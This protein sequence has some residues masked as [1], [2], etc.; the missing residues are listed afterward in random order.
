MPVARNRLPS[1]K[2]KAKTPSSSK[3][4]DTKKKGKSKRYS[5]CHRVNEENEENGNQ[6]GGRRF[7]RAQTVKVTIECMRIAVTIHSTRCAD[8]H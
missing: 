5:L 8:G 1:K 3:K 6:A 2:K 7:S 4:K